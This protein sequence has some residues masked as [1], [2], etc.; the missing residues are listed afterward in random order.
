MDMNQGTF[1]CYIKVT[2]G[3]IQITLKEKSHKSHISHHPSFSETF[4]EISKVQLK[5]NVLDLSDTMNYLYTQAVSRN[6]NYGHFSH[7]KHKCY[8]MLNLQ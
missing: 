6:S 7:F 3:T 8:T 1:K 4:L 2:S 5:Q